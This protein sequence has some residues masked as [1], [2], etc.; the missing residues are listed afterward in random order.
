[1][2]ST[3]LRT[4][5]PPAIWVPIVVN[6]VR[7]AKAPAVL[8]SQRLSTTTVQVAP[9]AEAIAILRSNCS[10]SSAGSTIAL[11]RRYR[12]LPSE[13][14][15]RRHLRQGRDGRSDRKKSAQ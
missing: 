8:G 9:K 14:G 4:I 10:F 2:E 11:G 5:L 6:S 1:M 13:W 7:T 12:E 15:L 3:S